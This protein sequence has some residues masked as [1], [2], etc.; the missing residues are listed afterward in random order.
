M[1][2]RGSNESKRAS[3]ADI[4]LLFAMC[5]EEAAK[6]GTL[7]S[8]ATDIERLLSQAVCTGR[9]TDMAFERA[10]D[11]DTERHVGSR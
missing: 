8:L 11:A 5:T 7:S 9:L 3:V 1:G 6:D 10:I 4:F 2:G